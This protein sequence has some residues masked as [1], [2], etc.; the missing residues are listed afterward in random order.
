[1]VFPSDLTASVPARAGCLSLASRAGQQPQANRR[2]LPG[3]RAAEKTQRT[4]WEQGWCLQHNSAGWELL[5]GSQARQGHWAQWLHG[6]V[7]GSCGC[8]P[9][10]ARPP[11]GHV[12][13]TQAAMPT[14]RCVLPLKEGL[15]PAKLKLTQVT[16]IPN[17]RTAPVSAASASMSRWAPTSWCW[18]QTHAVFN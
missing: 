12:S 17:R 5:G 13:F 11:Q 8:R 15:N 1:M 7:P 2:L 4:I 18:G 14:A 6:V 3:L 10:P 16:L 9:L